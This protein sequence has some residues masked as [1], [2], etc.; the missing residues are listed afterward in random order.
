MMHQAVYNVSGCVCDVSGCVCDV[1]GW[2]ELLIA[3]LSH[4][5][6]VVRDA[7]M[8]SSQVRVDRNSAHQMGIG[9]IFD[10]VL[11]ELVAKMRDMKMDKTELGCLRSI[12]LFNPGEVT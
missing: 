9:A 5:S 10:R 1:S 7:I 6:L 11:T 2:N 3:G 4:R 8:L 12:V